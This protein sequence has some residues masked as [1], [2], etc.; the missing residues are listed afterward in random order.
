MAYYIQPHC[1]R[2]LKL[3]EKLRDE[4]KENYFTSQ[5]QYWLDTVRDFQHRARIGQWRPFY[6]SDT[7]FTQR[8]MR[9]PSIL[10]HVDDEWA[11]DH[12]IPERTYSQWL[13]KCV[14]IQMHQNLLTS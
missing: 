7:L 10:E 14:R 13:L 9:D 3:L 12:V 5:R 1:P 11:R 8:N 4:T 6:T 2:R